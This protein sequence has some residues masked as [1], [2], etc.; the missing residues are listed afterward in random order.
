M[1]AH[2]LFNAGRLSEA[3]EAQLADVKSNPGDQG[4]RLFLF[5]LSVFAGDLDRATRQIEALKY[6]DMELQIAAKNYR[7][8][9]ESERKRR[10]VFQEGTQPKFLFEAPEHVLLRLE[11]LRQL[12]AGQN[13]QAQ[14]TLTTA[15]EKAPPVKGTL[16]EKPFQDLC[17]CDDLLGTVLEVMAK[18][19]YF[20][21]PLEFVSTIAMNPP[22][23]PR[24][25]IWAPARLE[26]HGS[27]SGEIYLPALYANSFEH[28]EDAVKLGRTSDWVET[29][30][31]PILGRGG[32]M[33]LLD[34]G[35]VPMLEWRE[36][37]V[38]E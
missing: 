4:K 7:D 27:E 35:S 9:L 18:G 34:E 3:I 23:F 19:E 1:N 20:W 14:A 28:A 37:I 38:D 5:E 21:V 31:G 25:L 6:D 26:T 12:R 15:R 30:N 2:E 10:L 11:A 13:E 8:L 17:D 22:R 32:R 29:P 16:N 24:D 36:L 33:F